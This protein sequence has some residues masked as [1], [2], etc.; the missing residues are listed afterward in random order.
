MNKGNSTELYL[1]KLK[2]NI[3]SDPVFYN[4]KTIKLNNNLIKLNLE[5]KF[6]CQ[7]NFFL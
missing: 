6:H 1:P 4:V 5:Y 2:S 3:K 7:Y